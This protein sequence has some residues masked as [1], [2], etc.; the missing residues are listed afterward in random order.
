MRHQPNVVIVDMAHMVA[1][2]S[3]NKMPGKFS[4][5]E[6]ILVANKEENIKAAEEGSLSVSLPWLTDCFNKPPLKP[7]TTS[8]DHQYTASVHPLTGTI[9]LHTKVRERKKKG[10]HICK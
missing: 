10:K 6:G 9:T 8:H 3:N 5:F 4:P 1:K 7:T 2:H